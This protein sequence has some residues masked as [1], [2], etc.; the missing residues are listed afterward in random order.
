LLS[1]FITALLSFRFGF[2]QLT[3]A[4]GGRWRGFPGRS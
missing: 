1:L 4:C 2:V 3:R